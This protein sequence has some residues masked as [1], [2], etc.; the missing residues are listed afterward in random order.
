MSFFSDLL[1]GT[2]KL[3]PRLRAELEAEGLVALEEGLPGSVRYSRFKAPGKRFHGKVTAERIGLG[4]SERRLAV[5]C[6]SGRVKLID[7]PFSDPRFG[8][9]EVF[10]QG[11]DTVSA[12]IDYD[13][14]GVPGVSGEIIVSAITPRA[15]HI[16]GQLNARLKP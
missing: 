16:V 1:L 5:Y 14:A 9:V 2:G 4:I 3:K 8:A 15:V 6:R 7:T 11:D 12:R 10:L 13:Q